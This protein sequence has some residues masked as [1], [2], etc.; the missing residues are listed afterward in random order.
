VS[1]APN[2]LNSSKTTA[3]ASEIRASVTYDNSS[4]EICSIVGFGFPY[5]ENIGVQ[6]ERKTL[7][8]QSK[9]NGSGARGN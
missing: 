1:V 4:S 2:L 5:L 9:L 7:V 3:V 8:V 6:L